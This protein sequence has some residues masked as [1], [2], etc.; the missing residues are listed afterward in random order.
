M[1]GH[2]L[3][4]FECNLDSLVVD[5]RRYPDMDTHFIYDH[6]KYY[7]SKFRPLPTVTVSID[8]DPPVIIA[9]H[10]YFKIA[11][12]LGHK[13][14][15]ACVGAGKPN[16]RFEKF[17]R[18]QDV[19]LIDKSTLDREFEESEVMDGCEVFF[20]E[21][22]LSEDAKVAFESKIADF[23]RTHD[24]SLL[25]GRRCHVSPVSYSAD[26]T[27]AEFTATIPCGESWIRD[28]LSTCH[29]I[30]QN[31]ARIKSLQ[32]RRFGL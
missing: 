6:L 24:S 13:S 23:F 12:E 18:R 11:R 32:G 26:S 28:F 4:V 27:R 7:C 3:V 30:D 17:L 21:S 25:A 8:H 16:A 22:P 10:K 15:R 20:F 2:E 9:G 1:T 5:E 29:D 19:Q 31:V 14:I